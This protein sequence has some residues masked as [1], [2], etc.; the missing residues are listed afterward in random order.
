MLLL[1]EIL[2]VVA[3]FNATVSDNYNGIAKHSY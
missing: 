3:L 1:H 2:P